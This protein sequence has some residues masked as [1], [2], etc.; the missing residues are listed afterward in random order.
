MCGN[1]TRFIPIMKPMTIDAAR[2]GG[3][4]KAFVRGTPSEALAAGKALEEDLLEV[5]GLG[6]FNVKELLWH[7]VLRK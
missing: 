6:E 2:F 4:L 1:N 3:H 5:P 7:F